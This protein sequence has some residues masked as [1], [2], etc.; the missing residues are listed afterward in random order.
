MITNKSTLKFTIVYVFNIDIFSLSVLE[1]K[2][3]DPKMKQ[4]FN[5]S[6]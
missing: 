3:T 4:M 5:I 1:V 6:A 2:E